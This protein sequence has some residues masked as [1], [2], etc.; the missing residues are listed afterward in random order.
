[1]VSYTFRKKALFSSLLRGPAAEWE[2]NNIE[3]ATTWADTREQLVIRFSGRW[4]KFRHRME[5]EHCVRDDGEEIRNFL[6][7]IKKIVDKGWLDDMEGIVEANRAAERQAQ[8]RKRR[9]GILIILY[10]VSVQGTYNE[11]LKST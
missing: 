4:N 10:E 1:M 2:E 9:N 5:V 8:G 11:R 3:N 6:H 7:R